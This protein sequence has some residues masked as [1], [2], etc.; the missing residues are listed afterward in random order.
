MA[1]FYNITSSVVINKLR[2][3][4]TNRL[5]MSEG[6]ESEKHTTLLSLHWKSPN[7]EYCQPR[8]FNTG[9]NCN[10]NAT[11]DLNE[12]VINRCQEFNR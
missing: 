10:L 6:I 7:I 4:T 5:E 9:E 1:S 3:E 12:D 11:R 2:P 8:A